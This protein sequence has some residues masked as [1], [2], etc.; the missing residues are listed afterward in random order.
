[1]MLAFRE[2]KTMMP[3]PIFVAKEGSSRLGTS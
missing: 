1:L 3:L 2:Q